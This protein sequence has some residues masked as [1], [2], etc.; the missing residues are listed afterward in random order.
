MSATITSDA[1]GKDV[2]DARGTRIGIV[3]AVHHG[4]AHVDPDPGFFDEIKAKLGWEE[5]SEEGYPLQEEAIAT[6]TD[7]EIRLREDL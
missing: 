5:K 3:S 2:V 4:T 6:I 7:D 1:V